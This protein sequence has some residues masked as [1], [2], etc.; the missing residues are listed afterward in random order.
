MTGLA[1]RDETATCG[2]IN[3]CGNELIGNG[4]VVLTLFRMRIET[5]WRSVVNAH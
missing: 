1:F 3:R 2:K 5:G 4:F